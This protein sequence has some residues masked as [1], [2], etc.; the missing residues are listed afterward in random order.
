MLL[1]AFF[2]VACGTP[3]KQRTEQRLRALSVSRMLQDEE[4]SQSDLHEGRMP[5]AEDDEV[6]S[7]EEGVCPNYISLT[8]NE[9]GRFKVD[10]AYCDKNCRAGFCPKDKC[11]CSTDQEP[12]IGTSG[13]ACP[14]YLSLTGNDVGRHQVDDKWCDGNCRGNFLS[15]PTDKCRCS[16]D[17]EPE[18]SDG[19]AA[20]AVAELAVAP[21]AP[22][23]VAPV[24]PTPLAVAPLVAPT[25]PVTPEGKAGQLPFGCSKYVGIETESNVW[26]PKRH[27]PGHTKTKIKKVDDEY[28]EKNCR[29]GFCPEASCR[30]ATDPEPEPDPSDMSEAA[31][32]KR[33]A[34]DPH[35][36]PKDELAGRGNGLQ[37]LEGAEVYEEGIDDGPKK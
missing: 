21:V 13:D 36:A 18:A 2:G 29:A 23:P 27:E 19:S 16:T 6:S 30:C 28:C 3:I 31:V 12:E 1:V 20:A 35:A 8:G 26:A 14:K 7:R 32:A 25:A 37:G 15:C 4:P 24:A 33:M 10:D 5:G 9:G 22:L 17:P 11:R 34:A